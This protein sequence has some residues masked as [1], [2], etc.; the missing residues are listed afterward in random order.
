MRIAVRKRWRAREPVSPRERIDAAPT[1]KIIVGLTAADLGGRWRP[2]L[3]SVSCQCS[4]PILRHRTGD[5][6]FAFRQA[7]RPTKDWE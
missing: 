1:P 3:E 2:R 6:R 7:A 4:R 5:V